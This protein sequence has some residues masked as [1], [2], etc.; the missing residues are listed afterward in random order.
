MV[1]LTPDP[2]IDSAT[3]Y[4]VVIFGGAFSGSSLALLLKRSRPATRILIVE[5]SEVFDRKVGES[6]SEVAGCFLTR[7]LGLS[8][9]LA[10]ESRD[11]PGCQKIALRA[12]PGPVRDVHI[13]PVVFRREW[14]PPQMPFPK[15]GGLVA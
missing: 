13:K 11:P 14:T 3:D 9:Y 12:G 5:K 1:S 6:T 8:N 2:D 15:V 7:V 10:Y 4:D